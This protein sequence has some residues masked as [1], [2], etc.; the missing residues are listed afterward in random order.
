MTCPPVPEG[1][2]F[3]ARAYM[4]I[5]TTRQL[6]GGSLYVWVW[7]TQT[8]DGAHLAWGLL[9]LVV[10]VVAGLPIWTARDGQAR[11]GLLLSIAVTSAWFGSFVVAAVT[12]P[13]YWSVAMAIILGALTCKDLTMVQEPLRNPFE[14]LVR[15]ELTGSSRG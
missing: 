8:R 13:G 4:A 9:F 12:T 7:A 3:R 11:A 1:M 10:A 5:I 6:L 2:T 15:E 14:A